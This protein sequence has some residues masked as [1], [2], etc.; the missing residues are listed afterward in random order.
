MIFYQIETM[1]KTLT[2]NAKTIKTFRCAETSFLLYKFTALYES[3]FRQ[4][5][6][7][8]I[9]LIPEPLK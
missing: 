2:A 3:D 7:S 8:I 1:L 9:S 6:N 5:P 4:N